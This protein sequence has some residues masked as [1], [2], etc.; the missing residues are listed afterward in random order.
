MT[1]VGLVALLGGCGGA[2]AGDRREAVT[3]LPAAAP[4][5]PLMASVVLTTAVDSR[6][7][8][9]A[10]ASTTFARDTERIYLVAALTGL[11]PGTSIGV[12]WFSTRS[13]EPLRSSTEQ[14][15]GEHRLVAAFDAPPGGFEAGDYQVFVSA[16]GTRLGRV[17][18]GIG[19][20][21]QDWTGVRGLLVSS[22]I[23]AWTG[24]AIEPRSS[25]PDGTRRVFAGFQVRTNDPRPFVRVTWLQGEK[26]LAASDLECGREVRCVDAYEKGNRIP[27][28]DYEVEVTVNGEVMA[29]R[30]F[31]VGGDPVGPLLLHAAL[32]V[33]KGA[34][35][36][37][38]GR[39]D[40]VFKGPMSG[41]RCGVRIATLPDEAVVEVVWVAVTDGG[42]EE[43]YRAETTVNGGGTRTAVVDWPIMGDLGPGRYKAIIN[44]GSRKLEELAFTIE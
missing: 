33:A 10:P 18:F 29:R 14:G 41:L 34:K 3:A 23:T 35:R 32:G 22:A 27:P 40:A 26:E 31:H 11:A 25:F 8:S 30:G 38:P 16:D 13:G 9:A 21:T 36:Q 4:A 42:D 44:L 24:E 28:G 2:G 1:L 37:M 7:E 20:R 17:V 15:S 19:G 39:H 6:G 12:S 5:G 43:R